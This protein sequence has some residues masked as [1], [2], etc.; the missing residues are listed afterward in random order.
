MAVKQGGGKK[1]RTPK[2]FQGKNGGG[3]KVSLSILEKALIDPKF[4][5]RWG[6]SR[7]RRAER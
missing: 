4:L 1:K 7:R 6:A 2:R 3:G 5:D